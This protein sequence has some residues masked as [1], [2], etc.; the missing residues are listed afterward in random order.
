MRACSSV[1][2]LTA[3]GCLAPSPAASPDTTHQQSDSNLE[4]LVGRL[5]ADD[6]EAVEPVQ[7][8]L[9]AM[10]PEVAP[11]LFDELMRG[12]WTLKPRLLEV[13]SRTGGDVSRQK[14]LEGS[15][16]ERKYAALIY[17]LRLESRAE[18]RG[19]AEYRAMR[20]EIVQGMRSEDRNLRALS[21]L[22]ILGSEDRRLLFAN[23]Y[24]LVPA[25]IASFDVPIILDRGHSPGPWDVPYW[26]ICVWLD[27][28][29]G[30]RLEYRE[31]APAINAAVKHGLPEG[32]RSQRDLPTAFEAAAV[33][34]DQLRGSWRDWWRGHS[35]LPLREIGTRLIER[36][37]V[38]LSQP[39]LASLAD[40]AA[41]GSLTLWTGV[42]KGSYDEWR[43]WWEANKTTYESPPSR[44]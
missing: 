21:G 26:A 35:H 5:T 43:D 31:L 6:P 12:D 30:D 14:L 19:T 8:A 33:E 3:V 38:V 27:E 1:L 23:Y 18:Q 15:P 4:M 28:L 42:S 13:L 17:G 34:I 22:A 16:A 41:S 11:T 39:R 2:A 37:L 44:P 10:G 24:E 36:N 29:I 7:E 32:V 25:L 20:E 40:N 9:R